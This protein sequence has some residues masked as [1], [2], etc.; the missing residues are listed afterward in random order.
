M[1]PTVRPT[2]HAVGVRDDTPS[3]GRAT[4]R[5]RLWPA[6]WIWISMFLLGGCC[7]LIAV[8]FSTIV[9]V[10]C[11][12]AVTVTLIAALLA[13]T[14]EVS[15][16][17]TQL[18]AGR[19]RVP[20]QLLGQITVLDEAELRHAHGRGLDAR[21]YLCVRAWIPTGLRVDLVDPQDP[22]PYWLVSSR[23]PQ[24]LLAALDAARRAAA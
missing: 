22:T 3:V 17:G 23:R 13:S 5:E 20:V 19:A 12:V 14:P 9:A 16:S 2:W 1:H 11:A 4:Y 10:G 15:V 7:G 6:P 21:A 24:Q 8:P 18:R